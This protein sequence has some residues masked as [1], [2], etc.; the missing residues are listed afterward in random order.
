M[1]TSDEASYQANGRLGEGGPRFPRVATLHWADFLR[2][3]GAERRV[4]APKAFTAPCPPREVG[5]GNSF[6]SNKWCAG[7]AGLRTPTTEPCWIDAP[8]GAR[9]WLAAPKFAQEAS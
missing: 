6:H 5:A 2:R 1:K 9:R 4:I 7:R 3:R 8:V